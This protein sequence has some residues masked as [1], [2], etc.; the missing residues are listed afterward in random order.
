MRW[1]VI[2]DCQFY[3]RGRE[4]DKNMGGVSNKNSTY[5]VDLKLE[6]GDYRILL[7]RIW[8]RYNVFHISARG[9]K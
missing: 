4:G 6:E 5:T 8:V 7:S 3:S 9:C 2:L 1:I